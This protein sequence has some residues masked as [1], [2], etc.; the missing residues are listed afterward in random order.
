MGTTL[1]SAL[2]DS[3][4]GEAEASITEEAAMHRCSGTT[5]LQ[6]NA[7]LMQSWGEDGAENRWDWCW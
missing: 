1:D 2:R 3:V 7:K 4:P 6:S 5:V